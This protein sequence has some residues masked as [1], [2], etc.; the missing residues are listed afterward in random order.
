MFERHPYRRLMRRQGFVAYRLPATFSI[1]PE[2]A[3]W[4]EL[5]FLTAPE[6][7]LHYMTA[8]TDHV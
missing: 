8:D 7:R 2:T 6:A 1:R 3:D 5:D 4:S